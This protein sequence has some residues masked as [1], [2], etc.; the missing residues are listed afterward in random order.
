MITKDDQVIAQSLRNLV[1]LLNR[2]L[3]K[4]ASNPDSLSVAEA[5]VIS[6]LTTQKAMYPSEIGSQLNLSSQFLSQILKRLE[7]LGYLTRT[8]SPDD[9]RKTLV[10]LTTRGKQIVQDSR[11]SREEWLAEVISA[12]FTGAEKK[13]VKEALTYLSTLTDL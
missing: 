6:L 12:R 1:T 8:A 7:G 4:Q 13:I 11:E 9:K 3:R 10:S 5:N 2:R